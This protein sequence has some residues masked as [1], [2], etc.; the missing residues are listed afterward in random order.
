MSRQAAQIVRP[1]TAFIL[2]TQAD[3]ASCFVILK[4]FSPRTLWYKAVVWTA[5]VAGLGACRLH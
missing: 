1:K 5:V 4:C 2:L 3:T